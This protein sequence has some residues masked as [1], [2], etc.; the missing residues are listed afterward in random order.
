MTANIYRKGILQK[1]IK[2]NLSMH[3]VR[4][5]QAHFKNLAAI[6]R[7]FLKCVIILRRYTLKG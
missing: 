3:N 7:R 5:G 1:P 4:N 2:F 6:A